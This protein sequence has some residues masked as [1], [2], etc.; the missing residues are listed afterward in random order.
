MV[1]RNGK[2]KLSLNRDKDKKELE[3][4]LA[5]RPS[6]DPQQRGSA[7]IQVEESE[8]VEESE[9]KSP[10]IFSRQAMKFSAIGAAPLPNSKRSEFPKPQP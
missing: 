9:P 10:N 2:V 7:G 5:R 6:E 3:V 4:T 1:S 8:D